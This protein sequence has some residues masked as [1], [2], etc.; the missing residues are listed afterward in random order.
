MYLPCS[1]QEVLIGDLHNDRC[2]CSEGREQRRRN[3]GGGGLKDR[4]SDGHTPV[5][6]VRG[7]S[8]FLSTGAECWGP[9]L[10]C[11]TP[12]SSFPLRISGKLNLYLSV[13]IMK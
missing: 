13:L 4:R 7:Y 12:H 5:T 6:I 11:S 8:S 2:W 9:V 3:G 1:P 10:V